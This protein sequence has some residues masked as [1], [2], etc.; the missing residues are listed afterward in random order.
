MSQPHTPTE[1]RSPAARMPAAARSGWA[2]LPASTTVVTPLR[3][4]SSA[5]TVAASSSWSGVWTECS[6]TDHSKMD[7]PG[8]SRSGMH[9]RSRGSPVRCWWVFTRPGVTTVPVASWTGVPGQRRRRSA[10]WP[11]PRTSPL[12]IA[13]A[14]SR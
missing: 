2:T 13:T 6:G 4:D 8:G 3:S 14:P 1:P 7:R 10:L 9:E 11:T 5:P 12:A